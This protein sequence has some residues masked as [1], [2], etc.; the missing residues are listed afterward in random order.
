MPHCDF[1]REA[2]PALDCLDN[3]RTPADVV[4]LMAASLKPFGGEFFC[5]AMLPKAGQ[6]YEE[7]MLAHRIPPEWLR[8]YLEKDFAAV[9]PSIR[10]FRHAV[11]PF[12]YKDAPYDPEREPAAA[13]V[14]RQAE[15]FRLSRGFMVP[16][17]GPAAGCE[18]GV[19]IGGY[20]L[21]LGPNEKPL[22]HLLALY[23]FDHIRALSRRCETKTP[24][25]TSRDREVLTWAAAGKTAS[26]I[27]D[28]LHITTRTVNEHAQ[29]AKRKL[30]AANR[31]QAIATAIREHLIQP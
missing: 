18:G 20:H 24:G 6:K 14:I 28:I 4:S 29:T 30:G 25:L 17:A 22:V 12:E 5:F 10:H 15:D 3:A 2:L 1:R 16:V 19:W 11:H 13:E 31:T 8:L 26:Q 27:G 21:A 23:A 7:V 9:D